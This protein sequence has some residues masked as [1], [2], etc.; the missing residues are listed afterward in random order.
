M[1]LHTRHPFRIARAGAS[2]TG[3]DVERIIVRIEHEGIFGFGEAVPVPY[4]R[5]SPD[6]VERTLKQAQPLL[7][8]T[9][10]PIEPVVDGL[11]ERFDDQRATVA[12]IDA[13]LHDWVGKR[14][15]QPVWR[16]LCLEPART[17]PT[18]MTI[19]LDVPELIEQKVAQA[20]A[21]SIL[22][23]KVGTSE[24][25]ATLAAVRRFAPHTR[26]RVDANCGWSADQ[27]AKQIAVISRFDLELIEQP[28]PAGSYEALR[29]LRESGAVGVPIIADE[30][31]IR[32]SDVD[33][34]AGLV[35]GVNIKLS[36]CGGIVEALRM[37]RL[38]Q[39]R[40]LAVMM[41]CMVETSLGVAAA[42]PLASLADY[43]DLDGHLLLADDPF[44]GLE[45]DRG[46]V[47]PGAGAGL[48]VT[49]RQNA[50]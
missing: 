46:V 1:H 32:P 47:K 23:V 7:P 30:D 38:A 18:S 42:A 13:A 3:R 40:G 45:L 31:C 50:R 17:P 19:G 2:V 34:L 14:R 5:Q 33:K 8:G 35:D 20:E 25:E 9:P 27:A 10:E 6:S 16:L 48:G 22:K 26:L 43:V 28:L 21:F 4:Y 36:K 24:D 49:V 29:R 44:T 41:G 15:G 11:L 39:E 37:I 12:A